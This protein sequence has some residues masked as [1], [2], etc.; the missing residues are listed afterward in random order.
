MLQYRTCASNLKAA[1][2][3]ILREYPSVMDAVY[4]NP[5]GVRTDIL[6]ATHSLP[7]SGA[8]NSR[9]TRAGCRSGPLGLRVVMGAPPLSL[10]D[11]P[12][13]RINLAVCLRPI[14]MP[15]RHGACHTLCMPKTPQNISVNTVNMLHESFRH[16]EREN[17]VDGFRPPVTT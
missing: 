6:P 1:H 4:T 3:T 10:P 5:L 16:E 13:A 8:L 12:A 11:R 7:G 15:S 9:L 14:T 17:L 2:P